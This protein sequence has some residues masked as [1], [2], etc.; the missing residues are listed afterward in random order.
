V[1]CGRPSFI[2]HS[3]PFVIA[4]QNLRALDRPA[5]GGGLA[6]GIKNAIRSRHPRGEALGITNSIAGTAK[7]HEQADVEQDG[8]SR[9]A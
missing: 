1:V 4:A 5:H 3:P 6:A 7:N 8:A 9:S 2:G